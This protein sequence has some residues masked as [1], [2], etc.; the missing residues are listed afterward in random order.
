ME[1]KCNGKFWI[2]LGA[3]TV[4]GVAACYLART[5]KAKLLKKKMCCAAHSAAEKAG[6]WMANVHKGCA[7]GAMEAEVNEQ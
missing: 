7:T 2:A 4:L 5:E 3:G 1:C 6:E